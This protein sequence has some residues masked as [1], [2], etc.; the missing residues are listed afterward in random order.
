MPINRDLFKQKF[1]ETNIP[2]WECPYCKNHLNLVPDSLKS[3]DTR[4][5]GENRDDPDWDPDWIQGRFCAL[6]ICNKCNDV[7]FVAGI[8]TLDHTHIDDGVYVDVTYYQ[9]THLQPAPLLVPLNKDIPDNIREQ[10]K[11]A[12][13][14]Y[15][16]DLNATVNILRSIIELM[17][18]NMGIKQHETV[19]GKSKNFRRR[20]SLHE[21]IKLFQ[22]KVRFAN[23]GI[24]LEAAKWIGNEGTHAGNITHDDVFDFA[25]IL[26]LMFEEVYSERTAN[27]VK[28]SRDINKR[29]AP[30]SKRKIKITK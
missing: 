10:I 30:R 20:L 24:H 16:C 14:L 2:A 5:S 1:T 4:S 17:L 19:I 26:E 22:N 15:W 7:F 29:K 27:L 28:M 13:E 6:F 3:R 12:S 8:R 25:D 9:P 11:R 18:T 23:L 21:R